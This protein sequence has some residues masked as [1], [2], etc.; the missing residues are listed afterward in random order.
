MC[1]AINREC[2]PAT[3]M[4]LESGRSC[5]ETIDA[6]CCRRNDKTRCCF[7]SVYLSYLENRTTGRFVEVGMISCEDA[8]FARMSDFVRA[9]PPRTFGQSSPS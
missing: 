4:S 8:G 5:W 1:E 3:C 9:E 2:R 7:C 6:A